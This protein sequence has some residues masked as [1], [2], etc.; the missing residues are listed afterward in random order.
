MRAIEMMMFGVSLVALAGCPMGDDDDVGTEEASAGGGGTEGPTLPAVRAHTEDGAIVE[1]DFSC[2]GERTAP[3]AGAATTVTL[4]VLAFGEFDEQGNPVAVPDA[5]VKIYAA[6]DTRGGDCDDGCATG[7]EVAPGMYEV[8]VP[9]SGWFSYWVDAG[10]DFMPTLENN[11]ALA[12][13]PQPT[14][15]NTMRRS[16]VASLGA[17]VATDVDPSRALIA[18][19]MLDCEGR[20]VSGAQLRAFAGDEEVL[21]ALALYFTETGLPAADP[22]WTAA[23]GRWVLVNAPAGSPL[24]VELWGALAEGAAPSLLGCEMI[25]AYADTMSTSGIGP[26][27]ADGPVACQ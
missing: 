26:L 13:A 6:N 16:L 1:A 4:P 12:P 11:V 18:G 10:A 17:L 21:D 25:E 5:S 22:A 24:R 27:R 2:L 9:G 20:P 15:L 8:A 14:W 7:S 23:P 3:A 19:R